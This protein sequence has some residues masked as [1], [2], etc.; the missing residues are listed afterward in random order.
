M[1][2]PTMAQGNNTGAPLIVNFTGREG[3][4][5]AETLALR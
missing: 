3:M 5:T 2:D 1:S 4:L